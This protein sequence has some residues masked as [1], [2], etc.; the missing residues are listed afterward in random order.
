M[1]YIAVVP[2]NG[3]IPSSIDGTSVDYTWVNNYS[4]NRL[5]LCLLETNKRI[6]KTLN[7]FKN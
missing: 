6:T 1:E 3:Y 2:K 7:A 4:S 5:V